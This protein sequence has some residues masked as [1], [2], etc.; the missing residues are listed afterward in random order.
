MSLTPGDVVKSAKPYTVFIKT[1][2]DDREGGGT[3]IIYDDS[4]LVITNAHVVEGAAIIQVNV[5]DR[6]IL[7]AQLIGLSPCDDL[8]VIK[9]PGSGFPVASLGDSNNLEEGEDVIV[10]GY[11]LGDPQPSVTRGIVSKL[12]VTVDQLQDLVQ[13]DASVTPGNSGGPLLNMRGDVVGIVA[14]KATYDDDRNPIAGIAYAISSNLV[15]EI[16][17][18]LARGKNR[19]W[20]GLNVIPLREIEPDF[21]GLWVIAV[22]D[23]SP[24]ERANL[25]LLDVVLTMNGVPMNSI[26]DLCNVIRAGSREFS[27]EVLGFDGEYRDGVITMGEGRAVTPTPPEPGIAFE[28]EFSDRT[29]RWV[30]S[31]DP[32]VERECAQNRY[33]FQVNRVGFVYVA[34][35][36][37]PESYADLALQADVEQTGGSDYSFHG[38]VFRFRDTRHYYL[39]AIRG[40]GHY[41]VMKNDDSDLEYLVDWKPS[42]Y[43]NLGRGENTLTVLAVGSLIRVLINGEIVDTVYDDS[44]SSGSI[45]L[46]VGTFPD[47]RYAPLVYFDNVGVAV[48]ER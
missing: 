23:N 48:A 6:G 19:D 29:C 20:I 38:V 1:R 39:F 43:I 16:T 11:P 41:A 24:A 21:R 37:N 10:L 42:Q 33:R 35:P 8:A 45:G 17:S 3:G 15:N 7:S 12:H 36:T 18:D 32:D 13:T 2:F 34:L 30:E 40:D 47:E 46:A 5:P 27:Y 22:S 25:R 26:A 31:L 4:G 44:F 9:V 14:V 28:D